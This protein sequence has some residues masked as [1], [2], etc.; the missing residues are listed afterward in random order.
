MSLRFLTTTF[1]CLT[2]SGFAIAAPAHDK[3][4]ILPNGDAIVVAVV[5]NERYCDRD[6]ECALRFTMDGKRGAVVYGR[7]D[8]EGVKSCGPKLAK[9]AWNIK[10]GSRIE[11]RGQYRETGN[12]REIDV[13]ASSDAFL[14]LVP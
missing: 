14:R 3:L 5:V 4:R 9:F 2:T 12:Y 6:A 1:A 11:A 8:V 10:D 7:G 13:C